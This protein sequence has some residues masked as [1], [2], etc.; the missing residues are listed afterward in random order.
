MTITFLFGDRY[1][2]GWLS[3]T[4]SRQAE[5]EMLLVTVRPF[6][7]LLAGAPNRI[8]ASDSKETET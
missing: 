3:Q 4:F 8:L 6:V 7:C 5:R 2:K 1:R